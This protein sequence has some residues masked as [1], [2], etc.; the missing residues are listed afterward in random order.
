LLTSLF[1]T[2][3]LNTCT[4]YPTAAKKYSPTAPAEYEDS[5]PITGNSN[6]G[7]TTT[8]GAATRDKIGTTGTAKRRLPK[9]EAIKTIGAQKETETLQPASIHHASPTHN[10]SYDLS[11]VNT[12]ERRQNP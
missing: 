11:L 6:T 1:S 10:R 8:A 12:R 3:A 4:N 7:K 5:K 9:N 2:H